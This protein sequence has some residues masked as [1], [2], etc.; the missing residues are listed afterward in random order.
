[1]NQKQVNYSN[2][3]VGNCS[4][5][6]YS[7]GNIPTT[8]GLATYLSEVA[9]FIHKLVQGRPYQECQDFGNLTGAVSTTGAGGKVV[10]KNVETSSERFACQGD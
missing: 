4:E 5:E 10:I 2:P 8:R 7:E 9:G 6:I 3:V 1:M